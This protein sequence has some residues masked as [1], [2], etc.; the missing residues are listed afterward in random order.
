MRRRDYYSRAAQQLLDE[1]FVR[2]IVGRDEVDDWYESLQTFYDWTARYWEQ[3]SLAQADPAKAISYARRAV[4]KY[5]DASTLTTLAIVLMRRAANSRTAPESRLRYW[6]EA[7]D[8]LVSARL[9][10]RGRFEFPFVA[11][12]HQTLRVRNAA[13]ATETELEA[14]IE[15]AV[16][17]W[18]DAARSAGIS[19]EGE[20]GGVLAQYPEHWR[21]GV[22]TSRRSPKQRR[23]TS[24]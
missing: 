1:V 10:G 24:R 17:S 6:R 3:R 22:S 23:T 8:R 14:E 2:Q 18:V 21:R 20:L 11:F 15:A 5:E 7:T 13:S 16:R 9:D 4:S 12:F 19:F